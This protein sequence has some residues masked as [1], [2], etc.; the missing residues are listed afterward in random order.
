MKAFA[1]LSLVVATLFLGSC[2]DGQRDAARELAAVADSIKAASTVDLAEF[3]LP[4]VLVMPEG[5]PPATKTWKDELGELSISAG[6]H[7]NVE[8]TEGPAD[9]DRLKG[10]LERDL[11]RKNTIVEEGPELLIYRSEFPDDTTLVF[12]HFNKTMTTDG[13]T[14]TVKDSDSEQPYTL[15]D[16]KKMAAAISPKQPA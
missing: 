9:M 1:P 12:F 13:R 8:I 4:L 15:E 6:D 16:V 14:F 2:G 11:L 5:L 10:D 3:H 7:F